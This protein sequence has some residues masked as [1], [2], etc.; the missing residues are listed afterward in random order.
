M[1][2]LPRAEVER[3]RDYPRDFMGDPANAGGEQV[4]DLAT[5]CLALMDERDAHY[6]ELLK[7]AR[8]H[9]AEVE[10]LWARLRKRDDRKTT[11]EARADALHADAATLR[12]IIG[13]LGA[14]LRDAWPVVDSML[15]PTTFPTGTPPPHVKLCERIRALLSEPQDGEGGTPE[16][17][18]F[19]VKAWAP[20]DR[21]GPTSPPAPHDFVAGRWPNE[22]VCR[23][24]G[25]LPHPNHPDPKYRPTSP[26]AEPTR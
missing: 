3:I 17:K 24:C 19:S 15:C 22:H 5:T 20:F 18:D 26:P 23:E 8:E 6:E 16:R 10:D 4:C 2:P 21:L 1:T 11:A 25:L 7:M 9:V 14:A 13:R 12:I